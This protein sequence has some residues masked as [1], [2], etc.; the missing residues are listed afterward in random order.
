VGIPEV[1]IQRF[2]TEALALDANRMKDMQVRKR[3]TLALSL[4]RVQRAQAL[5]DVAEMFTKRLLK[6]QQQ[7][8]EAFETYQLT[9]QERITRLI[10]ALRDV[11]EAYREEG[12]LAQRM[13]AIDI[14]YGG[15]S[16]EIL[17][18]CETHLALITN[19]YFPFLRTFVSKHRA[20]LFRFL[21]TVELRSPHQ[22]TALEETIQFLKANEQRTGEYLPICR[23][24]RRRGQP[25]EMVP[26][27]DLSWMACRCETDEKIRRTI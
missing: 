18:D 12:T 3:H 6:V 15:K 7:G 10:I 20:S 5:D 1:K 21:N 17:N 26:L 2:A 8:R 16:A 24:E 19:T 4:V 23:S 25:K 9:M 27:V 14:A 22:N 13:E 11:T